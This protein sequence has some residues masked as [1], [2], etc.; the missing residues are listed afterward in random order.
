MLKP[1][2]VKRKT[3]RMVRKENNAENSKLVKPVER[4]GSTGFEDPSV[5]PE[6]WADAFL[7]TLTAASGGKIQGPGLFSS[8]GGVWGSWR[9]T[10]E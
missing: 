6:Q 4:T 2:V 1:T 9:V 3:F 8:A 7:A 5:T 10:N